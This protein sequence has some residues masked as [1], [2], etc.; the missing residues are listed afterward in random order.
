L[1]AGDPRAAEG[2]AGDRLPAECGA[3]SSAGYL[4]ALRRGLGEAGYVEG[5]NLTLEY[6]W[7]EG[8]YDRLPALAADL[9]GH[10][11]D[12]IMTGGGPPAALAA[13]AATSI[14]PIVLVVG[15]DPV[16]WASSPVSRG[17]AAISR[18]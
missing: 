6:R 7:A 16:G 13:K 18:A 5:Q 4:A 15:T 8:D 1:A 12:V 11:V 10:K 3:W 2:D 9:V 14:I 17:R